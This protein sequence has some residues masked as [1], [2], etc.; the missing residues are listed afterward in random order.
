MEF[1]LNFTYMLQNATA[2]ESFYHKNNPNQLDT[3]T[4]IK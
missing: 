3:H 1:N 2:E 4:K